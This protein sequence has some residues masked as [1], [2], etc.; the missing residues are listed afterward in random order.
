MSDKIIF[1][2]KSLFAERIFN[3]NIFNSKDDVRILN[4][5]ESNKISL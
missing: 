5:C 1:K 2:T 3:L 4:I